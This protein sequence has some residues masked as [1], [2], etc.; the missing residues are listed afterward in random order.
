MHQGRGRGAGGGCE[1]VPRRCREFRRRSRGVGA[2]RPQ[3]PSPLVRRRRTSWMMRSRSRTT[4]K[5]T[6]ALYTSYILLEHTFTL[7]CQLAASL[8]SPSV[9]ANTELQ[10]GSPSRTA[11]R[12]DDVRRARPPRMLCFASHKQ[13]HPRGHLTILFC[14][15]VFRFLGFVRGSCGGRR[16]LGCCCLLLCCLCLCCLCL[17]LCLCCLCLVLCCA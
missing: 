10:T 11:V 1:Q 8:N 16:R 5:N 3:M 6:V 13:A 2:R 12:P 4:Y 9:F 17:R 15:I 7:K 14:R